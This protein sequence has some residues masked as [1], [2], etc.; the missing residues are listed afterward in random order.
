MGIFSHLQDEE[1]AAHAQR[2][3]RAAFSELVARF[4]DRIYRFL[5]R[6]TRSHD[7]A[8]ELTQD[9]FLNAYKALPRWTPQARLSTWLFRIAR[10][11]AFDWLRRGKRVD[12]VPLSDE[13]EALCPDP[14]PGPDAVLETVQRYQGLEASL[15]RLPT[16]HREILLLREIE[17]MSY[18]EIAAVLDIGL[19][20]VK[21]RIARA[22]AGLLERMPR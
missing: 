2:G 18:E 20:T 1:C 17:D 11:L 22:R 3:E 12:F 8:L 19:G 16:E 13:E 21:S 5:V 4:Q 10:N 14:A 15:A 6:L 7:D 9:T